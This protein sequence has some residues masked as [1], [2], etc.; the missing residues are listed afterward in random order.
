M[1]EKTD[2]AYT[3]LNAA[4]KRIFFIHSTWLNY[5]TSNSIVAYFDLLVYLR[6]FYHICEHTTER[7]SYRNTKLGQKAKWAK[8]ASFRSHFENN[9]VFSRTCS[10]PSGFEWTKSR[11]GWVFSKRILFFSTSSARLVR[12]ARTIHENKFYARQEKKRQM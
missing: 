2:T 3:C 11:S 5:N 10:G 4:S 12:D 9:A 6:S 7:I 8:R 1:H